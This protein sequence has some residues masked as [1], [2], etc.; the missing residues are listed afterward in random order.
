MSV[1]D[2]CEEWVKLLEM[3]TKNKINSENCFNLK[4]PLEK[5]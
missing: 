5:Y 4:P 1:D 2:F 3:N